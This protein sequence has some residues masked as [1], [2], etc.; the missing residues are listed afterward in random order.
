[1]ALLFNEDFTAVSSEVTMEGHTDTP[2][3]WSKIYQ[4]G[5]YTTPLLTPGQGMRDPGSPGDQSAY[6]VAYRTDLGAGRPYGP[7]IRLS[8]TDPTVG[9]GTLV[10]DFW[11]T[12]PGSGNSFVLVRSQAINPLTGALVGLGQGI[13]FQVSSVGTKNIY[14][15]ADDGS[16]RP[17]GNISGSGILLGALNQVTIQW[18]PGST[19]YKLNGVTLGTLPTSFSAWLSLQVRNTGRITAIDGSSDEPLPPIPVVGEWWTDIIRAVETP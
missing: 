17:A 4:S 10:V 16:G 15:G 3:V 1:M 8:D 6:M 18:A 9:V 5:F 13:Q 11:L 2:V 14:V 19:T 7:S 12:Q